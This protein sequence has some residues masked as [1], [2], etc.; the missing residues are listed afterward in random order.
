RALRS[1]NIRTEN[2]KISRGIRS[3]NEGWIKLHRR[4][5][6]SRVFANEGLLKVWLYCLCRANHEENYVPIKTGRG[7]SEVKVKPGQFISGRKSAARDL[8]MNSSTVYKRM[9]KLEN[10]GNINIKS[11][12]HYSV[13]TICNWEGYQDKGSEKEQ[14]EEQARSMQV[15]GKEQASNTDK[16]DN[17]E[18]NDKNFNA[19]A[20]EDSGDEDISVVEQIEQADNVKALCEIWYAYRTEKAKGNPRLH[21]PSTYEIDMTRHQMKQWGLSKS[22]KIVQKSIREGYVSLDEDYLPSGETETSNGWME[23]PNEMAY[24]NDYTASMQ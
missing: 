12:N 22:K 19:G 17:N 15:T 3:M 18:K 10:M 2:Q 11:N 6:D 7:E 23:R 4:I 13:I 9:K 16:N 5:I 1:E 20:R 21:N 8:K 24:H 14:Q